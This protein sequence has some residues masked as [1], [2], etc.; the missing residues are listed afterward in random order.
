MNI[1][2]ANNEDLTVSGIINNI[3]KS[4][5]VLGLPDALGRIPLVNGT[6]AASVTIDPYK[7]YDFGTLSMSMTVVFNT[8]AEVSG[9]ARQYSLR[10]VAGSGCNLTLPNGVMYVGNSSPTY[11]TGRTYEIDVVNNCA[12]VA[13]F[14]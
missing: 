1:K 7:M 2:L 8:S 6:A 3:E 11:T 5:G 4:V 9:Y 14:Y 12:V 13:E 10:F